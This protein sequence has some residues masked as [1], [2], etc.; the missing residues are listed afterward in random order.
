M[1]G[2][3]GRIWTNRNLGQAS[4]VLWQPQ[5]IMFKVLPPDFRVTLKERKRTRLSAP[6]EHAAREAP[7][8][9]FMREKDYHGARQ[10]PQHRAVQVK[11][12]LEYAIGSRA[13]N[14]R[15]C[16]RCLCQLRAVSGRR[17]F[18][19]SRS[20][21]IV[22][23]TEG[24]PLPR[25]WIAAD[26]T[27]YCAHRGR[28]SHGHSCKMARGIPG[29]PLEDSTPPST[30]GP[31]SRPAALAGTCMRAAERGKMSFPALTGRGRVCLRLSSA[32]Q[33][34]FLQDESFR[35]SAD[36]KALE[37]TSQAPILAASRRGTR[38]EI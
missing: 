4:R 33:A 6:V 20:L 10:Q 8:Q 11:T 21:R 1:A 16:L 23:L 13:E 22:P 7:R 27:H 32:S 17:E 24:N 26:K 36:G 29:V 18:S 31:T 28:S 9:L 2:I 5:A 38:R 34:L 15:I 12:Y 25:S 30:W 35:G 14:P 37:V 19:A 3:W